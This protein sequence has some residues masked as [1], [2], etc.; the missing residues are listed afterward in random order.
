M[1]RTIDCEVTED[2]VGSCSPGEAV[3]LIGVVKVNSS[4]MT[5]RFFVCLLLC[6]VLGE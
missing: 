5:F 4:S 3:V 6:H 1:P 2:L